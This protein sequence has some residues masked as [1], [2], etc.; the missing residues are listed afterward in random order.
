[1]AVD[2]CVFPVAGYGTRFLPVT[3][4]IPKEMLPVC[5]IPLIQYA[6]EEALNSG[7]RS[8]IMIISSGKEAIKHYFEEGLNLP[9]KISG[10]T[11]I[12]RLNKIINECNFKY[13]QQKEMLGLGHAISLSSSLIKN[14]NFAVILPD[15]L[16]YNEDSSILSQMTTIHNAYPEMCIVAVE[17]V[18]IEEVSNYGIIQGD[19]INGSNNLI[20]VS[21]LVEKPKIEDAPS[22]FAVIGRYILTHEIFNYINLSELSHNEIQITDALNLMAKDGKVI[23]YKYSGRRFDCGKNKGYLE[24][25][26]FFTRLVQ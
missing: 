15:D 14:S 17:E 20:Q 24:A 13:I 26:N 1:M 2:Y 9:S 16:C 21:S 10:H 6:V 5:S 3:K 4:S 18:I 12:L 19:F 23:A 7:I 25:N 11:S 8:N 22:K